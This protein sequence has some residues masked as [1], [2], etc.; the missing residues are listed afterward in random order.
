M[1]CH[2]GQFFLEWLLAYFLG[3]LFMA[4]SFPMLQ[5]IQLSA[6]YYTPSSTKS[7]VI[8]ILLLRLVP[9]NLRTL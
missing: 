3:F 6:P 8:T 5:A 1:P 7:M 4:Q 2:K 9:W